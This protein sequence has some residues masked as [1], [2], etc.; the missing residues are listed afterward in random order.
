MV[1]AMRASHLIERVLEGESPAQVLEAF[2]SGDRV[3]VTKPDPDKLARPGDQGTVVKAWGSSHV[4][5]VLD[6]DYENGIDRDVTFDTSSL[7][8][9]ASGSSPFGIKGSPSKSTPQPSKSTAPKFELT[10]MFYECEHSGDLGHYEDDVRKAGGQ[11][12]QARLRA[13]NEDDEVGIIVVRVADIQEFTKRLDKTSWAA[14][15]Y[16][17]AKT[18]KL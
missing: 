8:P 9:G 7:K 14:G 10:L 2:K 16:D 1:Q 15:Q 4:S 18:K 13:S 17:I 12:V 3:V 11:I 5:V 6:K